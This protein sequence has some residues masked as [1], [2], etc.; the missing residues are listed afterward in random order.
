MP[1]TERIR[2]VALEQA[3]ARERADVDHLDL[4]IALRVVISG[5]QDR[6]AR[7][8]FGRDVADGLD[9]DADHHQVARLGGLPDGGGGG[10]R[11]EFGHEILQRFRAA[12]V[13]QHH[14]VPGRHAEPGHGTAD[15]PAADEANSRHARCQLRAAP[16]HSC[17]RSTPVRASV[18]SA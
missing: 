13:A 17:A 18:T 14:P 15:H 7:Q 1:D 16:G 9:R 4:A 5:V 10:E 3:A 8:R 6:L 12:G 2:Q 11:A